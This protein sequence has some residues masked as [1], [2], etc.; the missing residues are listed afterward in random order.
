MNNR[1]TLEA[2]LNDLLEQLN[3]LQLQQQRIQD[4]VPV[5]ISELANT[6]TSNT[7]AN[8]TETGTG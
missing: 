8:P 1:E 3:N 7:A 6:T 4:R 2:E 5:I